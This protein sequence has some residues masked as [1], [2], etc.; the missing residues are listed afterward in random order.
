MYERH[1]DTSKHK[2]NVREYDGSQPKI[3]KI[4]GG[5]GIG[6]TTYVDKI[7]LDDKRRYEALVVGTLAAGG[8]GAAG[9]PPSSIHQHFCKDILDIVGYELR[10]GTNIRHNYQND[11]AECY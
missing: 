3:D 1:L 6:G 11:I 10:G 2:A 9:I 4:E 7:K 8:D 5:A